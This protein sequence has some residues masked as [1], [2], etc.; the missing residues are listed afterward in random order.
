[1]VNLTYKSSMFTT[2]DVLSG[3]SSSGEHHYGVLEGWF[4]M[5]W[6]NGR[7]FVLLVTTLVV[8]TLLACLKRVG[9]YLIKRRSYN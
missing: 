5:H 9:K 7:F 8:F 3:T 4:G 6:W 2:G 1:V